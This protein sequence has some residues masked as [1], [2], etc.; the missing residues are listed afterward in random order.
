MIKL[1]SLNEYTLRGVIHK[2]DGKFVKGN[3]ITKSGILAAAHL[4]GAGGVKKYFR[5]GFNPKDAYGTGLE[6]YLFKFSGFNI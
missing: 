3:R 4:A 2:Y 5:Y 6:D 1:L